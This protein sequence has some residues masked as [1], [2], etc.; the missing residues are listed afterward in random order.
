MSDNEA[1]PIPTSREEFYQQVEEQF[2]KR[3]L[4]GL[5]LGQE[6]YLDA[7]N[8]NVITMCTGCAGTGK[9]YI[10]VMRAI[11]LLTEQKYKR[12]LVA[13]PYVECGRTLGFLPGKEEEKIEPYMR[14]IRD[15]FADSVGIQ[16]LNTWLKDETVEFCALAYMRGRTLNNTVMILDEAQNATWE[17]LL[18]FLTRIGKDSKMIISGDET[19]EDIFTRAYAQCINK[20]DT[21][22]YVEGIE[23]VLL[24]EEDIVRNS[25]IEKIIKKMGN[26][27]KDYFKNN[28]YTDRKFMPSVRS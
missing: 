21:P 24:T 20:F 28:G 12:I 10:A 4:K 22:P 1:L 23:V 13:R 9:T 19:Q 14:P 16:Q 25:L 18:M 27:D 2:R 7:I 8:D 6:D 26:F 3:K 11:E 17:E 5:T 15:V